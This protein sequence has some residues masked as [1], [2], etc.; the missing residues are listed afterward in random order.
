MI[1]SFSFFHFFNRLIFA[2]TFLL[3]LGSSVEAR[4]ILSQKPIVVVIPSYNNKQ[5]YKKNLSTLFNQ[6]Y[7]NYRVVYIDDCSTDGTWALVEKYVKS[8]KQG[9]RFQ[10][11][12][13]SSNKGA[14]ENIY[15]AVHSCDDNE[16][17]AVYDGDDWFANKEVLQT[18]NEAYSSSNIWLTHGSFLGTPSN[19]VWWSLSIPDEVIKK[20]AFRDF[21]SP[22]HLRT[23]YAWL[24]KK[25]SKNDLL[26]EGKFYSMAWDLAMMF[27]MLE[28]AGERHAFIK[29]ILYIY[30]EKNPLSDFKTDHEYQ[31][32]LESH[33][34]SLP[35]YKRLIDRNDNP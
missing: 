21:R 12:K 9:H 25:I 15:D 3:V 32:R 26:Y 28:M 29:D 22:S 23:F 6:K 11:I 35:P 24:F 19:K 8:K 31:L 5:W 1:F 30:N 14:L 20:N 17:I 18:I 13:N 33:I 27:P 16:I 2:A 4:S 34:R 7:V 10:L